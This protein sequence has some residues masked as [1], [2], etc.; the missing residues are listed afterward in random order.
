M[1]GSHARIIKGAV[2]QVDLKVAAEGR[3]HLTGGRRMQV[4]W[5]ILDRLVSLANDGQYY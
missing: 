2:G 1:I 4:R 5:R 3:R